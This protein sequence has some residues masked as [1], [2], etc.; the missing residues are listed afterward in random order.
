MLKRGLSNIGQAPF[1]LND[2]NVVDK[3]NESFAEEL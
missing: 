3:L 1:L 2:K